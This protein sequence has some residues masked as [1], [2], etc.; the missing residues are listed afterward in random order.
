MVRWPNCRPERIISRVDDRST[1]KPYCVSNALSVQLLSVLLNDRSSSFP[2]G[3]TSHAV[4]GVVILNKTVLTDDKP[5][6]R[7]RCSVWAREIFEFRGT[8]PVKLFG[9][10]RVTAGKD[11]VALLRLCLGEVSHDPVSI[12]CPIWPVRHGAVVMCRS[13]FRS[14]FMPNVDNA[15]LLMREEVFIPALR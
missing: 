14:F 5:S 10:F 6:S 7:S 8:E 13:V 12:A 4:A 1:G 11:G 9:G 2:D 3:I 15:T